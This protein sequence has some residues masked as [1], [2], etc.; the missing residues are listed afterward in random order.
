MCEIRERDFSEQT[1]LKGVFQMLPYGHRK[2]DFGGCCCGCDK[3]CTHFSAPRY[4]GMSRKILNRVKK[5][6]KAKERGAVRVQ[7]LKNYNFD[8]IQTSCDD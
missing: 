5:V 2:R 1:H 3:Y 6:A 8:T 4:K 7:L